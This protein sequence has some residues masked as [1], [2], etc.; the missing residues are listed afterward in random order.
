MR[1]S[2][3][4]TTAAITLGLCL[5][6]MAD[7]ADAQVIFPPV[8][9]PDPVTIFGMNAN[10]SG[11]P[12]GSLTA[13]MAPDGSVLS[14][15]YGPEMA[16]SAGPGTVPTD[17]RRNC[18]LTVGIHVPQGWTFALLASEHRGY[19]GLEPNV[20]GTQTADYYV[21]GQP[22]SFSSKSQYVGDPATGGS[23]D[24]WD[25]VDYVPAGT[26]AQPVWAPC[27][28]DSIAHINE[29]VSVNN[30]LAK[31]SNPSAGGLMSQDATDI[32]VL[33]YFRYQWKKC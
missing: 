3:R 16:A 11:C 25:R 5:T 13:T 1:L 21:S 23:Y 17:W 10:G 12:V 33:V 30:F 9:P 19:Y 27:G 4:V 18:L 31:Q 22:N 7:S 14:I 20:V 32:S 28:K 2:Y 24:N 29:S 26:G 15:T 8:F 6:T